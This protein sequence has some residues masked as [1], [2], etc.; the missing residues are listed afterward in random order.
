[1][2]QQFL[3]DRQAAERYG[4]G[5]ATI[6]RWLREDPSF[7]R[8]VRFTPGCT[9]WSLPELLAWEASRINPEAG[10]ARARA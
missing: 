8:P 3:S 9:R 6:W 5:R 10:H 1:M 7:P 4:V 2:A